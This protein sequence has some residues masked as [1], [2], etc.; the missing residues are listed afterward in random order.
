MMKEYIERHKDNIIFKVSEIINSD[1][2]DKVT[3]ELLS[4]HL[5]DK[6]STSFQKYYFEI[7]T[8][9][10]I[11]LT[12]DNFFRDFKSQYSLQGIDNGYL[13]M[14]TTKKESILQL[15]K[16]DYLAELY[17]EHFAAA[18]IKH[19]ELKKP[20]ELGSFF[21]KLVH[22]F[23]PNEYCAL[24]NPIKNYLGM[25]REGFYFSFKVISQAYRQ[26]ISQNELIINKLRNEFQKIDTDNVMEHDRITDLKLIDLAMWTKANQVKE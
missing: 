17:F 9:E 26:W 5:S 1:T 3:N 16:N 4:F 13:G 25:K 20:R 2:I 6:R 11:F 7:L 24:D 21:A 18:M 8:N 12:S 10:T 22:T 14:L 15:I 23:K 19:G